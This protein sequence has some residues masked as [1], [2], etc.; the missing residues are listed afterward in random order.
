MQG[1]CKLNNSFN[2]R[3]LVQL[4]YVFDHSAIDRKPILFP[5]VCAKILFGNDVSHLAIENR[6]S[7]LMTSTAYF[8]VENQLLFF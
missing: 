6:D 1:F 4:E 3:L 2:E 7:K 5:F 8:V